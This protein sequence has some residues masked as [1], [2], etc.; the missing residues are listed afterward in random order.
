[1]SHAYGADIKCET[2]LLGVSVQFWP[3][4]SC[5]YRIASRRRLTPPPSSLGRPA[6]QVGFD[7]SFNIEPCDPKDPHIH[8][9]FTGASFP[10]WGFDIGEG[11]TGAV[12]I[13]GLNYGIPVVAEAGASLT[14][15]FGIRNEPAG[16]MKINVQLG[17]DAC[18][19]LVPV[20]EECLGK[21]LPDVFPLVFLNETVD[22]GDV[23]GNAT[24]P[25]GGARACTTND[26]AC[27]NVPCGCGSRQRKVEHTYGSPA[28]ICWRCVDSDTGHN[29]DDDDTWRAE[30]VDV[31][32]TGSARAEGYAN[33]DGDDDRGDIDDGGGAVAAAQRLDQLQSGLPPA[34][35]APG[36]YARVDGADR[37]IHIDPAVLPWTVSARV[38]SAQLAAAHGQ[39]FELLPRGQR[40]PGRE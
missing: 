4:Q 7:A 27:T 38:P 33:D 5:F 9:G 14:Y 2:N 32:T 8:V 24:S 16:G 23:C 30:P 22:A 11:R 34:P 15:E 35:W 3:N 31:N 19:R 10:I 1:M 6:P 29:Y 17:L 25:P 37:A 40:R 18:A 21:Y 13:P 39:G 12:G 26:W 20:M 28:V 36:A